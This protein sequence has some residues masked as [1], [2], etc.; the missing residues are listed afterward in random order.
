MK[1]GKVLYNY[2]EAAVHNPG[3]NLGD[4]VQTMAMENI[5]RFMGV[6]EEEIIGVEI[7]DLN[8]YDGEYV[9][10]PMYSMAFGIG[11]A[12]LPLSPR[13]IP[14]FISTHIAKTELEAAEVDYLRSYAP[15]GCRDEF[16]L[17]TMRKYGIPAFLSGCITAT[18]PLRTCEPEKRKAFFIDTPESLK[19][20][21]PEDILK[22]AVFDT[23]IVPIE[24]RAMTRE[25]AYLNY[26]R[27]R[28]RID[29]Y[30]REAA[31]MVSSKQHAIIPCMAAGIPVI[32]AAE[33]ISQRFSWFDKYIPIYSESTFSEIDWHPEPVAYEQEKEKLLR[34]FSKVLRDAYDKYSALYEVSEFYENRTRA[35]YGS[36]YRDRLL[37]LKKLG[38]TDFEYLIWGCGLI[39]NTCQRIM[40]QEFPEARLIA[41]A[42]NY[43]EG[44]WQGVPVIKPVELNKYSNKIII[45]ATYSGREECFAKMREL[46]LEENTDFVYCG[47][48]NG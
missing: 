12:K 1:F 24:N 34:L 4:G 43:V 31:L 15:I 40:A 22:D 20:Y 11:Y 44:E 46:G 26:E 21:I 45:L 3:Y 10:L 19:A 25:D 42:D 6:S 9:L 48:Q 47:T 7:C 17:N 30:M 8:T 27:S 14:V 33:N 41:A 2:G 5:Y 36:F 35:R 16:S 28:A 32:A 37:R 13:I 39:G 23:H 29:Q 38:K 18:M